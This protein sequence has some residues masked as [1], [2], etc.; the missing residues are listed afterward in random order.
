MGAAK[1]TYPWQKILFMGVVAGV[2]IGI[3]GLLAMTVG[4]NC[5]GK[6]L[7]ILADS[8]LEVST[9]LRKRQLE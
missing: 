5:P 9:R 4:G 2:Y 1:A 7:M 6:Q 3:G 8:V